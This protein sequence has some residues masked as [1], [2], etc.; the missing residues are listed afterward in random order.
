ME[1]GRQNVVI[2]R[3]MELTTL[4]QQAVDSGPGAADPAVREGVEGLV[5]ALSCFAPFTADDAWVKLGHEPS[6]AVASW[7]AVDKS[8]TVDDEVTCIV[9]VNGKVRDRLQVPAAITEDDLRALSLES[10]AVKK[11]VGDAKIA[12]VVVRAP[13]LVNIALA[14]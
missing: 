9:Q 7:P 1:G 8:L 5:I 14:R 11:A 2:A 4:L 13:K 10:D 6:V 12:K 3:L